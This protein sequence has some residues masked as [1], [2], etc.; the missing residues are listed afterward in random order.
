MIA[1]M[2]LQPKGTEGITMPRPQA[3]SAPEAAIAPFL[4]LLCTAGTRIAMN[5]AYRPIPIAPETTG[6]TRGAAAAPTSVPAA[7]AV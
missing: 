5:M 4:Q 7:H 1:M 6:G 3:M 2:I